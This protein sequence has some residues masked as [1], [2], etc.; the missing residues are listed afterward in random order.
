MN[1]AKHLIA[2]I[3]WSCL[4]LYS[5]YLL[6]GATAGSRPLNIIHILVPLPLLLV[7][8]RAARRYSK[9]RSQPNL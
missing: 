1:H 9:I 8:I 6:M 3:A 7:S 5:I 4:F 2:A